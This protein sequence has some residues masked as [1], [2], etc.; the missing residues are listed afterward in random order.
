MHNVCIP[1]GPA[2]AIFNTRVSEIERLNDMSKDSIY[3]IMLGLV[4][5]REE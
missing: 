5:Q 1:I 4:K 2:A 3:D